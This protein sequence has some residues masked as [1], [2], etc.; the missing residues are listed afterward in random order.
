[1]AMLLIARPTASGIIEIESSE[2]SGSIKVDKGDLVGVTIDRP[3]ASWDGQ[4]M[5][6]ALLDLPEAKFGFLELDQ[7][8][9]AF[10]SMQKLHVPLITVIGT[11]DNKKEPAPKP[12][13]SADLALWFGE[14][15]LFDEGLVG[16]PGMDDLIHVFNTGYEA[17]VLEALA[18]PVLSRVKAEEDPLASL[19]PATLLARAAEPV[20]QEITELDSEK[21]PEAVETVSKKLVEKAE[22][23]DLISKTTVEKAEAVELISK[24]AVEK[25]AAVQSEPE[26]RKTV[27]KAKADSK[28][29]V[30]KGDT[31]K[32][33]RNNDIPSSPASDT[34]PRAAWKEAE[35]ERLKEKS[36]AALR[37]ASTEGR[38]E[39]LSVDP[40]FLLAEK[41]DA[42][43]NLSERLAAES[44]ADPFEDIPEPDYE[45]L[46]RSTSEVP[47]V[48]V[49]PAEYGKAV[50]SILDESELAALKELNNMAAQKAAAQAAAEKEEA[51]EAEDS[52]HLSSKAR[53]SLRRADESNLVR[54]GKT[55]GVSLALV[56]AIGILVLPA[57]FMRHQSAEQTAI[58]LANNPP[59][60]QTSQSAS[61]SGGAGSSSSSSSSSKTSSQ[62]PQQVSSH[63][64]SQPAA[65]QS[66]QSDSSSSNQ[67]R[68][69]A[70][71]QYYPGNPN[72]SGSPNPHGRIRYTPGSSKYEDQERDFKGKL[73]TVLSSLEETINAAEGQGVDTRKYRLALAN[74]KF[75]A[76]SGQKIEDITLRVQLLIQELTKTI[77]SK[78]FER[79][80]KLIATRS[81]TGLQVLN[82]AT[83]K[84]G[85][86]FGG[87][88]LSL[89]LAIFEAKKQGIDTSKYSDALRNIK[90]DIN[91]REHNRELATKMKEMANELIGKMNANERIVEKDAHAREEMKR[92]EGRSGAQPKGGASGTPGVNKPAV[93]P[94]GTAAGAQTQT[95]TPTA[96]GVMNTIPR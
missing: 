14:D 84:S 19:T 17:D 83:P 53:F 96:P 34:S 56:I 31:S 28:A 95:Q 12:K 70:G 81:Q 7:D 90:Q 43:E 59:S 55:I 65:S 15:K 1:M 73:D 94:N 46:R 80:Q 23:V 27:E 71:D 30:E 48:E 92:A 62:S 42:P 89:E 5:L 20:E 79:E 82:E 21:T 2:H 44:Q 63:Q 66:S 13:P 10:A 9:A 76:N 68:A 85:P 67:S 35:E 11:G 78:R 54:F 22:A 75:S 25:A 33:K 24:T 86:S 47:V 50:A 29:S 39:F 41:R 72:P 8:D 16:G 88:K 4:A 26:S 93:P 57:I 74:L 91:Y 18:E 37:E 45:S 61:S 36:E 6:S 77:A 51:P 58:Q 32:E 3:E 69:A 52:D 49:T 64:Q 60:A 38:E 87:Q 40:N